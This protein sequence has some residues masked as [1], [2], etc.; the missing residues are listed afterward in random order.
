V[1]NLPHCLREELEDLSP[2]FRRLYLVSVNLAH[3]ITV[4]SQEQHDLFLENFGKQAPV[5][6][7]GILVPPFEGPRHDAPFDFCWVASFKVQKRADVLID[8]VRMLPRRRFL[9]VGGPGPDR[10]YSQGL[11]DQLKLLPNVEFRG[12]VPPDRV[13]EIYKEARI[14]L[15]TADWEG[16]PNGFLYAWSRGIPACSLKIDPDGAVTG[17][18]LGIVVDDPR[19]LAARMDALLEDPSRYA[20]MAAR[21]HAHVLARHGLDH[22]VDRF[23]EILP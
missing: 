14:F 13:G 5:I 6:P 7:N 16:F 3:R 15:N 9:V 19:E 18:D 12:F 11:M 23:L 8:M 20:A 17:G 21:C 2:V 1:A 4:Q 10:T 22:T